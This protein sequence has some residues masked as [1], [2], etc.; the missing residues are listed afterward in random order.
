MGKLEFLL[1]GILEFTMLVNYTCKK[2]LCTVPIRIGH[3]INVDSYINYASKG[4]VYAR[5]PGGQ[6]VAKA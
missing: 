6:N 2:V 1:W 3:L 4:S 5:W